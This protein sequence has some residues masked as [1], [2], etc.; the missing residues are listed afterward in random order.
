MRVWCDGRVCSRQVRWA[1]Y[2][3]EL[4][5]RAIFW[6]SLIRRCVVGLAEQG[7]ANLS[8]RH[9]KHFAHSGGPC[10]TYYRF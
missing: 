10:W 5:L 3:V 2:L 8:Y 4:E 6:P 7:L 1:K 9:E